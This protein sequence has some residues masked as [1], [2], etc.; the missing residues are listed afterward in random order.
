MLPELSIQVTDNR[1]QYRYVSANFKSQHVDIEISAA[2]NSDWLLTT[3]LELDD[4]L[5]RLRFNHTHLG[6]LLIR[7]SGSAESVLNHDEALS[8]PTTHEELET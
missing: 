1:I 5:C 8:N 7:T 4:L 2:E 3:A 6:T